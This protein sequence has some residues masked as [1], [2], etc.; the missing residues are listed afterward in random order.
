MTKKRNYYIVESIPS[1]AVEV[2]PDLFISPEGE[3]YIHTHFKTKQPVIRIATKSPSTKGNGST[4]YYRISYQ[5]KQVSLHR[6]VA[7]AFIENPNNKPQVNHIDGNGLNN[8]V[9]NLEWCT[10]QENTDHA[11]TNGLFDHTANQVAVDQYDSQG[12]LLE[13]YDSIRKA[14]KNSASLQASISVQCNKTPTGKTRGY[15]HAGGYQWRFKGDTT[16]L[17][18]FIPLTKTLK[19]TPVK[20]VDD[21]YGYV[22]EHDSY[23]IAASHF[24][25]NPRQGA[26]AIRNAIKRNGKAYGFRWTA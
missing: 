3:A 16:N 5:G 25:S 13:S 19:G 20:Q 6:L 8:H 7:E 22:K 18:K 2:K 17:T 1:N 14:S 23:Y 12:N 24:T 11:I 15:S 9:S 4:S 21:V 26:N 10:Q